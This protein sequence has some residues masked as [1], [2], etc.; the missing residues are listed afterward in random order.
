MA[1]SSEA[2]M[3]MAVDGDVRTLE[4]VYAQMQEDMKERQ[5]VLRAE[6][7]AVLEASTLEEFEQRYSDFIQRRGEKEWQRQ[8]TFGLRR[9][10]R[11]QG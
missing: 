2:A 1:R 9:A 6:Y 3:E 11:E 8:S 4:M 5:E 10:R 7:E